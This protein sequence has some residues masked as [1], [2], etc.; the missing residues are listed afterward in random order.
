MSEPAI[1][2]DNVTKIYS[3][4]ARGIAALAGVSICV[5]QGEIYGLLGRNGAGKTTLVKTLLDIVRPTTGEARIL[6][7]SSRSASTRKPVGYLPEDH[8]FPDY[9][10]GDGLLHYYAGLSGM[11]AAQCAVRVPHLLKLTG[12]VDA[13]HRKIRTYSKGMKQRLGLAQALVHDPQV[14]FL[15]EPTDGVDPVGRAQIRD[16]LMTL[17]RDGKTIFLNSHLLSEV[18]RICDRIGIMEKGKLVREGTLSALTK[19]ETCFALTTHP[20]VDAETR[21]ALSEMSVSVSLAN[22]V[23]L[24]E[25]RSDDEIDRVVDLLRARKVSV[26]GIE[27]RRVT[28]EEVFM[29]AVENTTGAA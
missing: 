2:I 13:A 5:A 21:Q 8:R 18:E 1:F 19:T 26:R 6:G 14:I 22:G 3:Q 9:R 25:L 11:S 29:K 27:Q 24:V 16:V 23:C 17:K 15:D 20:P 7:R 4:S 28:L 12:L 10:T